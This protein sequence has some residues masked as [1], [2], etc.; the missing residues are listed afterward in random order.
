MTNDP[1]VAMTEELQRRKPWGFFTRLVGNPLLAFGLYTRTNPERMATAVRKELVDL[2]ERALAALATLE[3][4]AKARDVL[5]V[6]KTEG[7]FPREELAAAR[8]REGASDALGA[9]LAVW[10]EKHERFEKRL[11]WLLDTRGTQERLEKLDALEDCEE[12][13]CWVRYAFRPEHVWGLWGNAIERI[14]Q[15]EST[16]TFFHSTG[17]A[18]RSPIRRTEDTAIFYAYFFNWGLDSYHGRKAI[19]GMNRI[20]GRYF[21]HNDGMKYVLLNAAFTILDGLERIGHRRL[22]DKERLGYFHAQ[23]KLGQAMNIHGL[24][25]DWDEMYEWFHGLNRLF[26]AHTPQK[27]RMFMSIEKSFDTIMKTPGPLTKLRQ[28]F[29]FAGM[30]ATYASALGVKSSGF[31]RFLSRTFMW[32]AAKARALL[33][34]EPDAQSLTTYLTYPEGVDIEVLGVKERS[35]KMPGVCP[36]AGAERSKAPNRGFP[37]NMRPLLAAADATKTELPFVEWDEIKKHDKEDDLWVVFGGDV[38]DLSAFAKNHPGGLKVL[39]K[40]VGRDM[41]KAFNSAKHTDI[42]KVFALNYRIGRVAE[43]KQA[44]S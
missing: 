12:I 11:T 42:T 39:M 34:G 7:R 2:D 16:A 13:W 25:H 22:T 5:E 8:A 23:V 10:I 17:E 6:A 9:E 19:E 29:A 35:A 14:A 4:A 37:E 15:I 28:M 44:A 43:A 24:T 20:H 41:T 3:G 18:E 36:F 30:D 1:C 26:A 27:S 21:I 31:K 40:G 38:Y 32:F 33:P